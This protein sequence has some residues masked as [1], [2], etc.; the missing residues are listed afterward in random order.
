[1][2][3]SHGTHTAL[4]VVNGVGYCKVQKAEAEAAMK[5]LGDRKT[6]KGFTIWPRKEVKGERRA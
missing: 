2:L 1:M 5:A 4:Y 6:G 3:C